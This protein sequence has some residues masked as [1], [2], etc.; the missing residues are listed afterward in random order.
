MKSR[1][2]KYYKDEDSLQRTS[3]NSSLYEELY[4]DKQ[5]PTSNVTFIDTVNEIDINKIKNMVD[6]RENYRKNKTYDD[7]MGEE[8]DN[9]EKKI[10]YDFDEIDETNY[11]INKLIEKKKSNRELPEEDNKLRNISDIDYEVLS[12]DI[13]EGQELQEEKVKEL[14][15][16]LTNISES[17]DLFANLKEDT[18]VNSVCVS[19]DSFYTSTV[20]FDNEDFDE[21]EEK[22]SG[23]SNTF[24]KVLIIL[25]F[26]IAIG[27]F[28]WFKFFA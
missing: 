24:V 18:K 2:E 13:D 21:N 28:V 1:M 9:K 5:E 27:V 15:N 6:N 26:L 7:L 4:K 14:V 19:E 3:R 25:S 10:E 22:E 23:K 11:D 12:N 16:T 8:T 20:T 17:T